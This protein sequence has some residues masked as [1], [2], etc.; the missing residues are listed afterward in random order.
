MILLHW[1][2]TEIYTPGVVLLFGKGL[3]GGA[4]IEGLQQVIHPL[5]A[6]RLKWS[7][8]IAHATEIAHVEKT[9]SDI[10]QKHP[11]GALSVVWSAGQSGFGSSD[12]DMSM[13]LKALQTVVSL[14]H[15]VGKNVPVKK[16][17]FHHVSSAGGLFEG[18]VSVNS[19][20]VPC[21]LRPYGDGKLLQEKLVCADE[22]LGAR[23]I[24]RPSSVY[25]FAPGG[26]RGLVPAL[27]LAAIQSRP[28]TIMGSLTTQRDYVFAQDIGRF[29]AKQILRPG[30]AD[31][32]I[33]LL[34][35][36]RPAAIFEIIHLIE[37]QTDLPLLRGID[38]R[39]TNALD[40]T[41]MRSALPADFVPTALTE[42][43]ALTH[44]S[45][46]RERLSGTLI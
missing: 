13:E 22:S 9:V 46:T 30:Q 21:P 38:P 2:K 17:S 35:Q 26:R 45:I 25:G 23:R 44:S 29:I 34:A 1:P 32:E 5:K 19:T 37:A 28:A 3:I 8:P 15:E 42:G 20:S 4:A 31:V 6:Q 18:Q 12:A 16:R 7:W 40:N 10:I 39:P 24:Y 11:E 36:G 27:I 41:F 43:I 14:A 33:C